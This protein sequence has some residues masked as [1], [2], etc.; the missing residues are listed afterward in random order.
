M[1]CVPVF[2]RA[3]GELWAADIYIDVYIYIERDRESL[4]Q[5]EREIYIYIYIES[6]RGG[7]VFAFWPMLSSQNVPRQSRSQAT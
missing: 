4:R 1:L 6:E 3:V 5:R 7:V 2:A